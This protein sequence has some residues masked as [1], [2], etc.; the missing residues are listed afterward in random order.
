MFENAALWAIAPHEVNRLVERLTS[1]DPNATT[2]RISAAAMARAGERLTA[3]SFATLRGETAVIP[4]YG[5]LATRRSYAFFTYE[6]IKRDLAAALGDERVANIILDI[7]SP[8]GMA[9]GCDECAD[10]IRAAAALKPVAAHITG[11]GAS[12]AYWLAA[13]SGHISA[14]A[15]AIVGSVGA[16]F[17]YMDAGGIMERFGATRVKVVSSQSPLKR[18]DAGSEEEREMLQKIADSTGDLFVK[19]VARFRGVKA[20]DVAERYGRG[21]IMSA[22]DARAAGMI[23]RVMTFDEALARISRQRTPSLPAGA[24][25]ELDQGAEG[26]AS[27]LRVLDELGARDSGMHDRAAMQAES[28]RGASERNAPSAGADAES[29]STDSDGVAVET[30]T[31]DPEAAADASEAAPAAPSNNP[32]KGTHAMS[33]KA[34][35]LKAQLKKLTL[36]KANVMKAVDD[37]TKMSSKTKNELEDLNAEIDATRYAL[38]QQNRLDQDMAYLAG[39]EPTL[40]GGGAASANPNAKSNDRYGKAGIAFDSFGDAA[41]QLYE[42]MSGAKAS[43][44]Y[45]MMIASGYTGRDGGFLLPEAQS[46]EA[47]NAVFSQE[48]L[49]ARCVP[50]TIAEKSISYPVRH[51]AAW[52]PVKQGIKAEYVGENAGANVSKPFYKNTRVELFKKQAIVEVPKEFVKFS[53]VLEQYILEEARD[54]VE[55]EDSYHLAWGDGVEKEQGWMNSGALVTVAAEAGQTSGTFVAENAVKMMAAL[56]EDEGAFWMV[57]PSAMPQVSLLS[58]K[59][60]SEQL[61]IAQGR[62]SDKPGQTLLGY[63]IVKHQA[64]K[65]IGTLGDITLVNPMK[66]YFAPTH[67]DGVEIEIDRS[68]GFKTDQ[69]VYKVTFWGG[70]QSKRAT[71]VPSRFG[72]FP[73]SHFVALAAR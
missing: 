20:A 53:D 1:G 44:A 42:H 54:Q 72:N 45:Q 22:A 31:P 5:P 33:D 62:A 37:P 38:E 17:E 23:D 29:N 43:T 73:M 63:P 16:V 21:G 47:I 12:G 55:W 65:N 57:S 10:A 27:S 18:P 19:A 48:S 61:F 58:V 2:P 36:D 70:G 51:E 60:T 64:A 71:P 3:D 15:T 26:G 4:I 50:Q 56:S 67:E 59:A 46:A 7:E 25:V 49:R 35:G 6:D 11:V 69:I 52:D 68:V 14:A 8:G 24:G 39:E 41:K 28:L 66:G 34:A 32:K 30:P 9:S 40:A 13:A